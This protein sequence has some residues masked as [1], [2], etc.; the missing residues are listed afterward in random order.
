[1]DKNIVKF[2]YTDIEEQ[3]FHQNKRPFFTN[4]IDVNNCDKQHSNY[5]IGYKDSEKTGSLCIFRP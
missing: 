2:E 5:L 4:D 3:K 1:M